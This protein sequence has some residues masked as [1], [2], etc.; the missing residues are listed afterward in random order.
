MKFSALIMVVQA[1]LFVCVNVL[2]EDC[3]SEQCETREN[4]ILKDDKGN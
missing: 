1:G 2:I 4:R 3:R